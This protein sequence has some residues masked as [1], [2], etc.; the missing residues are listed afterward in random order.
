MTTFHPTFS[1]L[2]LFIYIFATKFVKQGNY[3]PIILKT[4]NCA[5]FLM[6]LT[7]PCDIRRLD[8]DWRVKRRKF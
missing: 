6:P 3:S 5:L 8:G 2:S 7:S 4:K 1:P